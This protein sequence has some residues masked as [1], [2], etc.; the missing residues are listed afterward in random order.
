MRPPKDFPE[1]YSGVEANCRFAYA[2]T[3][4]I[5]AWATAGTSGRPFLFSM[6]GKLKRTVPIPRSA[7]SCDR[8]AM[9][10]CVIGAPAPWAN[11]IIARG[12]DG[13]VISTDTDP[14]FSD[15][16]IFISEVR[17]E[18]LLNQG[19]DHFREIPTIIRSYPIEAIDFFLATLLVVGIVG[20]VAIVVAV[21]ARHN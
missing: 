2:A 11:V 10:G 9:K 5:V 6:Y 3:A 4:S 13:S 16:S 19:L 15:T 14:I 18:L 12:E 8:E 7:S 17:K 20:D 1:R 21:E